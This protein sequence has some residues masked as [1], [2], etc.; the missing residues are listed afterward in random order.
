MLN[1]G[2]RTGLFGP[3]L[4]YF[5]G[6]PLGDAGTANDDDDGPIACVPGRFT[7]ELAVAQLMFVL[8]RSRSMRFALN[9]DPEVPRS[10]WRWT[11]LRS[12]LD[13]T[14]TAFDD[15]IAMGAKFFPEPLAT[16]EESLERSCRTDTGVGLAPA[17]GNAQTILDVFDDFEPLGGTPTAEAVRIAAEFMSNRRG[18]ART[19]VLATD[20]APN[21]NAE[22][23]PNTCV[24]TGDPNACAQ[25]P[26][27]GAYSCLDDARTI[28]TLWNV[29]DLR[30][31][32][33]YVVGIGIDRPEFRD[34]LE[35]MAIAG[36]RP[37]PTAPRYYDVQSEADLTGALGTI[38]D[39]VAKCTYLTP[40]APTRPDDIRVE[41]DGVVVPR[42]PT[43]ANGWDWVDQGFGELAFFGAACARASGD[44]GQ[45]AVVSGVV[46][47]VE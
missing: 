31:I 17:L 34:V 11:A 26:D 19:L 1:C 22:L 12:A 37:R 47:C 4:G 36:G 35:D 21:C 2:S 40:S 29:A 16:N 42:D 13:K 32:P 45:S 43:H 14:I 3:D 10:S 41:I 30:K 6:D 5:Y 7:F 27:R 46:T 18:T 20:G 38:R 9:G 24:C 25:F 8:D 44:N 23:D 15:Q 39:A 33:I 28:R